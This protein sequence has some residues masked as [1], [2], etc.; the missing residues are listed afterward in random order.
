MD[1]RR[2]ESMK[3]TDRKADYPVLP[4]ILHRWSPRAMSGEEISKEE[5]MTLFDAARWAPSS[6]N[7]QPWRFLYAARNSSYFNTFLELLMEGNRGW[8]K[9]AAVLLVVIS[10]NTFEANG[11][12]ERTHTYDTGAAWQNLALQGSSMGLVVHGMEGFDYEKAKK[13]LKIP[14]DFQV[15]AMAAIGKPAPKET[16]PPEQQKREAPSS[17]KPIAE[18]AMEGHFRS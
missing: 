15:E 9:N 6:Y 5:L 13:T 10:R 8:C 3:K 17:R 11:K 7:G 14:D 18:I 2:Y 16:L 4:V 1:E 12:P